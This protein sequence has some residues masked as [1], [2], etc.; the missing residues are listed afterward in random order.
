LDINR[1]N[2]KE[3]ETNSCIT[4][5]YNKNLCEKSGGG[6]KGEVF[7]MVP[8]CPDDN[9][10]FYFVYPHRQLIPVGHRQLVRL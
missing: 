6:R 7:F 5:Q 2:Q 4:V 9:T 3:F 10:D 1:T 8:L